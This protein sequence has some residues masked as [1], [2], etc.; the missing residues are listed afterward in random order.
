MNRNRTNARIARFAIPL[1]VV[2]ALAA[3]CAGHAVPDHQQPG[4]AVSV[5]L[6]DKGQLVAVHVGQVI[7][8]SLGTPSGGG[9]WTVAT[10]PRSMLS[11]TSSDPERGVFTF[12]ARSKGQGLV[13][14][15]LLGNCGPPLLEVAPE[16]V[17]C[18]ESGGGKATNG[19]QPGAPLPATL[20]TYTIRV[21]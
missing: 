14:F 15:S 20:V 16:A 7:R 2:A 13:G 18:P 5:G 6:D 4:A 10:Y 12:Q 19:V 8:V 1:A 17:P 9:A 3:A 11:V 21:S